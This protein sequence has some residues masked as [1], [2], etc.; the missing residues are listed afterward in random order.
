MFQPMPL[1]NHAV[2]LRRLGFLDIRDFNVENEN[3]LE[4]AVLKEATPALGSQR[5]EAWQGLRSAYWR[6]HIAIVQP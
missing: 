6:W 1:D 5:A 2:S 4:L 3:M